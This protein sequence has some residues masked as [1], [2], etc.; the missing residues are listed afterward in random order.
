MLKSIEPI[1]FSY[2]LSI[3]TTKTKKLENDH[4]TVIKPTEN[5]PF[6]LEKV[7]FFIVKYTRSKR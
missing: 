7:F 1:E 5:D 2:G 4:I 3:S 6:D